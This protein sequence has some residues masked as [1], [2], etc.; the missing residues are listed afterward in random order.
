MSVTI[1]VIL[2]TI[3]SFVTVFEMPM[4][5]SITMLSLLPVAMISIS[6]GTKWGFFC[7]FIFACFQAVIGYFDLLS[8]GVSEDVLIASLIVDYLIAFTAI[9]ISGAFVKYELKGVYAGVTL[10]LLIRFLCHLTSGVLLFSSNAYEGWSPI[11]Y[12]AVYN[13]S[14]IIP[15]LIFT[16]I[17]ASLLFQIK[18][19]AKHDDMML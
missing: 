5:G 17:G 8:W 9:G 10:A 16:M 7:S 3:L 1:S 11:A 14:Y 12:S 18:K 13:A 15:E 4:G 19:N 6:Y 2:S